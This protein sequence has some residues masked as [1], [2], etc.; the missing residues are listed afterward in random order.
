MERGDVDYTRQW[1]IK[2]IRVDQDILLIYL[3]TITG[4]K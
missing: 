2:K 4:D 3:Y 1:S